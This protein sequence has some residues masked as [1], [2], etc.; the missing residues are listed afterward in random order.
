MTGMIGRLNRTR[1]RSYPLKRFRQHNPRPVAAKVSMDDQR[2]GFVVV[3]EYRRDP[4]WTEWTFTTPLK[5][6]GNLDTVELL[7]RDNDDPVIADAP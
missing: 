3:R 4:S 2:P 6:A 1:R 5:A 7:G